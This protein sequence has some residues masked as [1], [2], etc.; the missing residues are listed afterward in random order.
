[1]AA[2]A[3]E[4][5]HMPDVSIVWETPSTPITPEDF[6][7][8]DGVRFVRPY[9]FEF[10]AHV[11]E[12]WDKKTVTNLFAEEFRQRPLD[13]YCEAV[14]AGRILVNGKR[15]R[16]DYVVRA[17]QTLSHFVHRHEPPVM[18]EPVRILE[19]SADVV[20]IWKPPSVPVHPCGQYRKNTVLGILEAE[21]SLKPLYPIHRLDRLVSG[22]LILARNADT[23]DQFRK[24]MEG[25]KVAKSYI[26]KVKGVF[27]DEEME[28]SASIVYDA[29]EGRSTVERSENSATGNSHQ[30]TKLL[31]KGKSACTKF[32]RLSTDGMYSIVECTPLT[33]RTHQ[34]LALVLNE[35]QD[36]KGFCR[37]VQ[38][39]MTLIPSEEEW[40][41]LG[42]AH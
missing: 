9:F 8:H 21:H 10:I 13:Y 30:H 11:K 23:A 27:P 2:G 41:M 25:G 4:E 6:I 1:M 34:E 32:K 12:R 20:T 24:E 19:L 15:V 33:G 5:R 22:L 37:K 29:R 40:M 36:W 28:L 3:V 26:A 38:A 16:S 42:Y 17:S 7:H 18:G 14:N 35:Q 39:W 31:G